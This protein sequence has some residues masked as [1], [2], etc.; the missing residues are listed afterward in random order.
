M[1]VPAAPSMLRMDCETSVE[2]GILEEGPHRLA[3]PSVGWVAT[4]L[5]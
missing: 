3:E 5:E 2:G 4:I 1:V